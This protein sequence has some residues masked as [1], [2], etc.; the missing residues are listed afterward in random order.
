MGN[1]V[2]PHFVTTDTSGLVRMIYLNGTIETKQI[3]NYSSNH[4]FE[5]V[6]INADGFKDYLFLD[7]NKLTV[8]KQNK[9]KLFDYKFDNNIESPPIY[10]YFSYD[11]RKI[12]IVAKTNNEIF[13]FNSNGTLYDGFP[14]KGNTPFTIGFL[15]DSR[16]Q[17]NLIVGTKYNFLYNY[18]VD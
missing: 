12:G 11:D 2:N 17:F 6:D 9:T 18:S 16:N 7:K 15:G 3:E 8:Y 5:Y 10:Y 14:L 1:N 4:F 13:L